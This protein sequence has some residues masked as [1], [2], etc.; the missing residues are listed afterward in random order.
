MLNRLLR[1]LSGG[2]R[3]HRARSMALPRIRHPAVLNVGGGSKRIAIPAHFDDWDHVLLDIKAAPGVD[4][5]CDAREL[6]RLPQSA[7]EAVYCSHNLEHYYRH[8]VPEVLAGFLH[9]LAEDGFCEIR[10]PDLHTVFQMVLDG[11]DL[12]GEL[13]VSP[14]GPIAPLDVVYGNSHQIERSGEPYYAHKTGFTKASLER[15]LRA[16]GFAEVFV[17]RMQDYELR[18]VALKSSSR[19]R[20]AVDAL[21]RLGVDA[22]RA[23][24]PKLA[25]QAAGAALRFSP[26]LPALHY[27]H[28]VSL[29]QQSLDEEAAAAL[30]RC[31]ALAPDYPLVLEARLRA[32]H[33]RARRDLARGVAP[34][35]QALPEGTT[36]LVSV[37]ICS[38][39]PERLARARAQFERS[40]AGVN[41]EIVPVQDPE[42]LAEGY[43]QGLIFSRGEILVFSH[44][45]VQIASPDFAAR[46]L[47]HLGQADLLGVAGATR[48]NSPSWLGAGWPHLHG[49]IAMPAENGQLL[50]TCYQADGPLVPEAQALDGAFLACRREVAEK[51]GFD[52]ETFDGWHG[53]DFDFSFRAHLSGYRCA[54]ASDLLLVHGS[55]GDFDSP[56]W[57]RYAER[58]L[59]K[60]RDRLPP[61]AQ[62]PPQPYLV[63]IEVTG[64]EEW[65]RM[66]ELLHQGR[67][68]TA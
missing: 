23:G 44:D 20:R 24:D 35:E 28:G 2:P 41:H 45:D 43:N 48:V 25:E 10:V 57:R 52:E 15:A 14:M 21:Y 60:H 58:L 17:V 51:L 26:D 66:T 65:R 36:P 32:A 11:L 67:E 49:Q 5:A 3:G 29:Y 1:Q 16:A 37:I 34:R 63:S 6:G 8:E 56:E 38:A 40:L 59:A 46:L 55:A 30:E 4:L 22:W 19:A 42:S 54:V 9:V 53:Y 64:V 18:A 68:L 61:G 33:A 13:Y 27:L 7:F 31:V 47:G 62:M 39:D 50:V 12:E